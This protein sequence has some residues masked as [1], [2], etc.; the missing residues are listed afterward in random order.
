MLIFDMLIGIIL[1]VY[2][3]LSVKV[4]IWLI[5]KTTTPILTVLC[6]DYI[7]AA[8]FDKA[9]NHTIDDYNTLFYPFDTYDEKVRTV[10]KALS[11]DMPVIIGMSVPNSFF[12]CKDVWVKTETNNDGGF[13]VPAEILPNHFNKRGAL[14]DAKETDDVNPERASAGTHF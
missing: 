6:A 10:K 9:R 12:K 14:I 1:I 7:P 2:R 8:L 3:K 5:P 13:T 11:Q 4:F